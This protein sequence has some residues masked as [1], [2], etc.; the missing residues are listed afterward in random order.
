MQKSRPPSKQH[1]KIEDHL[2]S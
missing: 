1:Q 2:I